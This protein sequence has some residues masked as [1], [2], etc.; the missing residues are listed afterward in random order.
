VKTQN[1][2][3]PLFLYVLS[4]FV[5]FALCTPTGAGAMDFGLLLNQ[6]AE[7]DDRRFDEDGIGGITYEA[8]L[9]PRFSLLLGDYHTLFVSG[10]LQVIR[11]DEEWRLLPE[12]LRTEFWRQ[13]GDTELRVG[14]MIYADPLNLVAA[15]LFDGVQFSRN[16]WRGTF[17]A[18]LW[19]TGLLYKN[20]A[21]IS[22]TDSDGQNLETETDWDDV[23]NTYFASRRVML[24]LYWDHPSV[25]ELFQINV[26]LLAQADVN[27]LDISYDSIY[28]IGR[29]VMPRQRFIFELG[30][31]LEGGRLVTGD[32][33]D[34][35]IAF[36]ADAGVHWLPPTQ[37]YSMV[38]LTGRFTSGQAESGPVS[39]FTPITAMPNG[40]FLEG[41]ISGLSVLTL[42]YT[43]RLHQTFSAGLSASHFVR[44]DRGTFTGYPLGTQ[45]G[46]NFFLGTEFFGRLIWSPVSDMSLNLGAGVFLPAL[47]NSAPDADPRWL[48]EL[49]VTLALF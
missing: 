3:R 37:V 21:N 44:S 31:A 42:T 1:C 43:A 27:D 25:A 16:T 35:R 15:G 34:F 24:A 45:S 28:L 32:D 29:V 20:R 10:S 48:V 46:G 40:Y 13:A 41:G 6:R 22:M 12:L 49:A 19:Y 14:R 23:W 11:E 8:A 7:I 18:G 4:L 33:T 38:S 36:A 26:T 2:G 39:A 5:I 9:I 17:G 47:G 30:G